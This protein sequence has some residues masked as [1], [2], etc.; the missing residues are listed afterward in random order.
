[1]NAFEC[2]R[3]V[4]RWDRATPQQKLKMAGEYLAL[5]KSYIAMTG[6]DTAYPVICLVPFGSP[7]MPVDVAVWEAR[8]M[9]VPESPVHYRGRWYNNVQEVKEEIH[10]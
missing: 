2:N 10:E 9:G 1:M 3:V 7:A 6:P 8:K 4:A 5:P